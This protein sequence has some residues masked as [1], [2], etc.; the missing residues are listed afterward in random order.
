MVASIG[1]EEL[2]LVRV[3]IVTLANNLASQSVAERLGATREVEA[4]NRL[5]FNGQP[6]TAVVYSL[7]PEDMHANSAFRSE[8]QPGCT[9][10]GG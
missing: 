1:F 7:I 4:R 5:I 8:S 9:E 2:G 10:L 3:E 6:R